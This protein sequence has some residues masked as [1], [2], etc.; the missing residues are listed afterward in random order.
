MERTMVLMMG[1]QGSGKSTFY[2]KFLADNFVRVNL[3]TLKTRHQEQ[4]LISDCLETGKSFA[5]DNT[6]PTKADRQRYIPLAQ[7]AGYKVVGY[8]MESKL[9]ACI[10]RNNQRTGSAMIPPAAIAATSNKLQMPSYDEG[11]DELYFVKN[12][13][14]TMTVEEWRE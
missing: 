6:N 8:F 7:F 4:L 11:F 2:Q 13:G 1:I 3:D 10:Q 14:L 9:Q 12:D 5:I